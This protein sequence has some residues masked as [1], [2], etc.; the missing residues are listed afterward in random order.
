MSG[1]PYNPLA[2]LN[3]G[4]SVAEALLQVPVAPLASTGG[5]VGAGVYAIYYTG[6]FEPYGPIAAKNRDGAFTQPIY[7]GKA[8]PEGGRKGGLVYDAGRG[9]A[10][11]NRLR[12][13]ARSIDQVGNI[14]LADFYFRSLVVDDIW[15]PLG[16]NMLIHQYGPIWNLVL[17]GFGNNKPGKGRDGQILSLW[18]LLH[19][20]RKSMLGLPDG[21]RT[22]Q[23]SIDRLAAYFSGQSVPM[24]PVEE[25]SDPGTDEAEDG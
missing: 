10:L 13:H 16:E 24:I 22:S 15:I 14:N 23:H 18:D 20:G 6:D 19:P 12:N 5:L 11:R 21:G 8:I 25:A 3:L 9:A 17:D 2:K 7:V 4:R 1:E